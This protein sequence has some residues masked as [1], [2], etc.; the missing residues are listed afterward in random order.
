MQTDFQFDVF[1]S[2]IRAYLEVTMA[3]RFKQFRHKLKKHFDKYSTVEEAKIHRPR[4]VRN[5]TNWESLCDQFSS[6]TFKVCTF[7][8]MW[9]LKYKIVNYVFIIKF[10]EN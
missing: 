6:D 1:N 5:Q 10:L 2:Q 4:E 8:F 7:K 9:M 3:N